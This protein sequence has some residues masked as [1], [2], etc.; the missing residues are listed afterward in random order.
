MSPTTPD[1][2][3][4]PRPVAIVTG[5]TRGIGSGIATVLAEHGYDLLLS[6]NSNQA[7]AATF[8]STTRRNHPSCHVECVGGD[9]A[10]SSV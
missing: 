6:Y 1:A 4:L 10:S 8:S 2:S 5:G 3:A 7:T 9:I